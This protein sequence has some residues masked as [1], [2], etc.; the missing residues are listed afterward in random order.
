MRFHNLFQDPLP[1][2]KRVSYHD[3][4]RSVSQHRLYTSGLGAAISDKPT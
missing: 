2:F 4:Q 1:F 3:L